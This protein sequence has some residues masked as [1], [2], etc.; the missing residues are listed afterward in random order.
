V[1]RIIVALACAL[2]ACAP[3]RLVAPLVYTAAGTEPGEPFRL[4]EPLLAPVVEVSEPFRETTLPN[5]LHVILVERHDFPVV[6]SRLLIDRGALDVDD[7]GGRQVGE[8]AYL[9]ARGGDEAV[10]EDLSALSARTG[11]GWAANETF[12]SS[13]VGVRAP[14]GAF[15][16]SISL[17]AKTSVAA[18]LSEDEYARRR[19]EWIQAAEHIEAIGAAERLVLFDRGHPYGYKGPAKDVI[20][21]DDAQAL[22]DRLF[23]PAHATLVVVGDVTPAQVDA[24]TAHWLGSW[25]NS[26]ALGKETTAPELLNRPSVAVV[27]QPSVTQTHAAVF[28]RGPRRTSDD[29]DAFALLAKILGGA[30]STS[31]RERLREGAGATYDVVTPLFS[32]RTA[33]WLSISASYDRD[34]AVEGVRTVLDAIA[35]LRDGRVTD[36]EVAIARETLL[37]EWR[38]RM[39]TVEGA[40]AFYASWIADGLDVAQLRERPARIARLRRDDLVR[41]ARTYLEPKALR[42]VFVGN[43]RSFDPARLGMG[44]ATRLSL[45]GE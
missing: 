40:A 38:G 45:W 7:A 31:L 14:S 36:E 27:N 13:T 8:V 21:V 22:H 25:R 20:R 6:A 10:F 32:T 43:P 3:Q 1:K 24:S 17:I 12:D 9:F 35:A 30:R 28:A 16:V 41:V 11:V 19:A 23:Q 37:S 39:S 34:K 29:A 5:G 26:Q 2:G 18:R 15:D 33:S 44:E 42:V 4:R